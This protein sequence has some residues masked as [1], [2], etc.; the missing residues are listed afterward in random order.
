MQHINE[1]FSAYNLN[2]SDIQRIAIEAKANSIGCG[3]RTGNKELPS[4]TWNLLDDLA[5]EVWDSKIELVHKI[6][7]GFQLFEI[8]PSYGHFLIPFYRGI[9]DKE[10][11]LIEH[12]ELI[13][14]KF[15]GCLFSEP[16]YADP[17]SYVLWVEFFEDVT[18]VRDN[19]Q[20]LVTNCFNEKP[21][22]LLL[23]IAGPVPFDLKE[24]CYQALI[25]D[26]GKHEHILKSL[27]Y[28]A[29]DVYGKIDKDKAL[30]ILAQLKI[31]KNSENYKLLKAKLRYSGF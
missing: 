13:W 24:V 21:L 18:T 25:A 8:F 12:K 20:G 16:Y 22:L 9:R 19:W 11:Y 26:V 5:D 29:F 3:M 15:I 1:L 10:I 14:G 27:L 30:T 28:S 6:L 4:A 31:D 7:L 17:T 2:E 23:K